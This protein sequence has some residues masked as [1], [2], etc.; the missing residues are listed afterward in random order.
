[1]NQTYFHHIVGM[2]GLMSA[3][4]FG[5]GGPLHVAN[6]LLLNEVST[7]FVN[8]RVMILNY[9]M[10]Q[11]RYYTVNAILFVTCFFLFRICLNTWLVYEIIRIIML[12]DF[13]GMPM[14]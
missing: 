12:T 2:T 4:L 11:S 13:K 10:G 3:I 9:E 1:M 7:L 8:Y 6:V 5:K 14:W